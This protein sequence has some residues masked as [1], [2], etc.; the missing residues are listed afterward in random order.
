MAQNNYQ[1]IA[2][3][4]VKLGGFRRAFSQTL[5]FKVTPYLFYLLFNSFKHPYHLSIVRLRSC[6][7]IIFSKPFVLFCSVTIEDEVY[8]LIKP[9]H[10]RVQAFLKYHYTMTLQ[11]I[12]YL[13]QL[14][15][16]KVLCAILC[17]LHIKVVSPS[18]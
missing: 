1:E 9:F 18:A 17:F 16:D 3:E 15:Y 5:S 10:K 6:F 2:R 12:T 7:L 11:F 8:C 13:R 14:S 4:R